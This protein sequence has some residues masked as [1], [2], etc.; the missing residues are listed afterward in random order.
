MGEKTPFLF[1]KGE[2]EVVVLEEVAAREL[3]PRYLK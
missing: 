2:S 3:E 1:L